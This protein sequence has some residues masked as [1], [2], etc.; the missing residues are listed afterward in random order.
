HRLVVGGDLVFLLDFLLFG[1]VVGPH[2]FLCDQRKRKAETKTGYKRDP[3][4][5]GQLGLMQY[6]NGT[7]RRLLCA[8]SGAL[9]YDGR[10]AA[11]AI[12]DAGDTYG[13]LALMEY[14]N[15]RSHDPG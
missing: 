6:G 13:G 12:A 11:A 4:H 1:I 15:Q 8:T 7:G 14:V 9:Q 5:S 3:F 2:S 10:G